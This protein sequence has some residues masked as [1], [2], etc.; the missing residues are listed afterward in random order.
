MKITLVIIM[1]S[2]LAWWSA[3]LYVQTVYHFVRGRYGV[4]CYP[5]NNHSKKI[6]HVKYYQ[7]EADCLKSL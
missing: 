2:A 1:I 7:T 5:I 6:Q 4:I 3:H